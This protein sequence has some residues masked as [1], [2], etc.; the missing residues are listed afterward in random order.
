MPCKER[1]Q[2]TWARVW[3]LQISMYINSPGGQVTAGLAIYDTMQA[4][5]VPFTVMVRGVSDA[6][7]CLA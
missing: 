4:R 1:R 6:D 5:R 7:A 2:P 3:C